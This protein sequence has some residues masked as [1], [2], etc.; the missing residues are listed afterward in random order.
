[1]DDDDLKDTKNGIM[2]KIE[3]KFGAIVDDYQNN[4]DIKTGLSNIALI[5]PFIDTFIVYSA[6][7][8]EKRRILKMID[9]LNEDMNNLN[10]NKVDQQFLAS[11][12]FY[13]IIK[14]MFFCVSNAQNED[15]IR[16]FCRILTNTTLTEN[17]NFR[18]HAE[19]FLSLLNDLTI[20]DMIIANE[21]YKFQKRELPN[22]KT[23]KE[24]TF[25]DKVKPEY[26]NICR[27]QGISTTDLEFSLMKLS[28]AGLMYNLYGQGD[29]GYSNIFI[30]TNIFHELVNYVKYSNEPL[31]NY[32]LRRNTITE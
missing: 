32:V 26:G 25:L 4:I 14:R 12:A 2:S 17:K 24:V 20:T 10:E 7:Y 3:K 18:H 30:G 6:Q 11:E 28:K 23:P 1:M 27:G 21:L 19:D 8:F 15:K 16:L 9:F 22:H 31:F 5:G 13:D 29:D